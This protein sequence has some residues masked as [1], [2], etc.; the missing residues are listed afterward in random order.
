MAPT[1]IKIFIS[2]HQLQEAACATIQAA[3]NPSQPCRGISC[4]RG[5]A[6]YRLY[7]DSPDQFPAPE[8]F[9][10][11]RPKS[12]EFC[13]AAKLHQIIHGFKFCALLLESSAQQL[14]FL[15]NPYAGAEP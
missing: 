11:G 7:G 15:C 10:N 13:R 6:L 8:L 14:R 2:K 12:T 5:F 4:T 3:S 1:G 9:R